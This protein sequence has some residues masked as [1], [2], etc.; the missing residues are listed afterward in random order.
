VS[1]SLIGFLVNGVVSEARVLD[2]VNTDCSCVQTGIGTS[3][4][5]NKIDADEPA[6]FWL[7][8]DTLLNLVLMN[9]VMLL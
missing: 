8:I 7:D 6:L 5:R 4:M 3:L 2:L 1:E 9:A